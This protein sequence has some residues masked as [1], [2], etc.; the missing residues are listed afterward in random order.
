MYS[1]TYS[2]IAMYKLPFHVRVLTLGLKVPNGNSKHSFYKYHVHGIT[3]F[4]KTPVCVTITT[5][6]TRN[7]IQKVNSHT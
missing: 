6:T 7:L 5:N 4:R 3:P 1:Y 2:T